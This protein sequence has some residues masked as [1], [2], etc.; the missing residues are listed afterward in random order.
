[1]IDCII[2]TRPN[3][4]KAIP[5]YLA[6][7]EANIPTRLIHTNQHYDA[8]LSQ[9][10]FDELARKNPD[11]I[12]T[13]SKGLDRLERK[14]NISAQLEEIWTQTRPELVLVFGD[15]D[16]TLVAAKSALKMNIKIA[17]IES[18]LRSKDCEM[19]EELNRIVVDNISDFCF[20]TEDSGIVNLENEAVDSK[21]YLVGNTMIDTL[22]KHLPTINKSEYY[23][24]V[25]QDKYAVLTFHRI[26]NKKGDVIDF[27]KQVIS[28][29]SKN[30]KIVFPLHPGTRSY[31]EKEIPEFFEK[32]DN[33]II[34]PPASYLE[35]LNL[36]VN[37][38]C[39]ITDS[40]GIQE[41]T[42]YLQKPCFT[43]RTS[44]ERPSTITIGTNKLI[45]H[46]FNKFK[47]EF[48]KF[49]SGNIK[50]EIPPLWD[51]NASKRIVDILINELNL[52]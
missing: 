43:L 35:F 50:G 17:H 10:F 28:Y 47:D 5:V 45:G 38:E 51:G 49:T 24:T 21:I 46:N 12:L 6:L 11:I 31:L 18:G 22:V 34:I 42:T 3:Y 33:L 36:V 27:L 19:P 20:V 52:N 48:D 25:T 7:K 4:M 40:G 39:I 15:V 13:S 30:L 26:E 32:L 1:M 44:T 8:K 23:K 29:A 16:S 2:G 41:E 9:V 37:C 14:L